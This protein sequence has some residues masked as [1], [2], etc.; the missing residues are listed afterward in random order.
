MCVQELADL[1]VELESCRKRLSSAERGVTDEQNR[2]VELQNES[3]IVQTELKKVSQHTS[4][5]RNAKGFL[6]ICVQPET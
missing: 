3:K 5:D 6:V 4:A 2:H 1:T